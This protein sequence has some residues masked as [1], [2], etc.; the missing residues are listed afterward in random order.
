MATSSVTAEFQ[1]EFEAERTQ[2]FRKRFLWYTGVFGVLSMLSV[3]GAAILIFALPEAMKPDYTWIIILGVAAALLYPAAFI[4]VRQSTSGISR[5][6]MIRLTFWLILANALLGI[7][8]AL[9]GNDFG[10][11]GTRMGA[12]FGAVERRITTIKTEALEA[13]RGD[14]AAVPE[15]GASAE[16][17]EDGGEPGGSDES[18][19]DGTGDADGADTG[20]PEGPGLRPGIRAA[21]I[22]LSDLDG[23][24]R[25]EDPEVEAVL[26]EDQ[27]SEIDRLERLR[28]RVR[29]EGIPNDEA[30]ATILTEFDR[31][32][33]ARIEERIASVRDSQPG[34]GAAWFINVMIAHFLA[35]LFIPWTWRECV[36]AMLPMVVIN[37]I[38]TTIGGELLT[39][40]GFLFVLLAP[41]LGLPGIFVVAVRNSIFRKKF[42]YQMLRGRYS[43]MKRELGL[44][45]QIH[46]DLFPDPITEGP[47]RLV[48]HYEPMR[49][50]GGDY[51]HAR[52]IT[53]PGRSAP[54]LHLCVMD[55]TGHGIGAA[56]TVNR[57]HGEMDRIL[58]EN[59]GTTPGQMLTGLNRYMHATLAG[60][61]V[62]ATALCLAVDVEAGEL[63][64][65]SAGHPPAFLRQ[66]NGRIEELHSTTFVLGVTLGEDFVPDEQRIAFRAGDTLL[67][68]TD[69]A[70][71]SRNGG[72]RQ[73]GV[74]G[75]LAMFSDGHPDAEAGWPLALARKV[76]SFRVGPSQDDILLVEL[77]RP[78]ER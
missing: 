54:T 51:L 78:L 53:L 70:I 11:M 63:R 3:F 75:L 66:V 29:R 17:Q 14:S 8:G 50:I 18:E 61:S 1:Q 15:L 2:W 49:Q 62:Y 56:L 32:D 60:H 7:P 10:M 71:E 44:A 43:E 42:T 73:L 28:D 47:I 19:S 12:V 24:D 39:V 74:A 57:L 68:Y 58:A 67:A 77:Y 76:E 4:Y 6:R 21:G 45:R 46:E 16:S 27:K 40:S 5:K 33:A 64:W 59:P 55:V 26:S 31:A 35:A 38:G 25:T 13:A 34:P 69:G 48:Y 65:A 9:V 22:M 72:N 23:G 30:F 52:M 41:L 37:A 20:V 36:F